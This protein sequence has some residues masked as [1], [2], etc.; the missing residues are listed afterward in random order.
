MQGEHAEAWEHLQTANRLQKDSDPTDERHQDEQLLSALLEAFRVPQRGPEGP[1]YEA[2]LA[3]SGGLPDESPIFVVGMPRS[4]STLIEQ[5]L[6][7]HPQAFGAGKPPILESTWGI[8]IET[9][10]HIQAWAKIR[11]NSMAQE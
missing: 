4:G 2:L 1:S 11:T 5:V 10:K 7:S 9:L 8:L 6:A 3:G